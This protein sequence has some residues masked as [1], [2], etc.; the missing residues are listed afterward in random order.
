MELWCE[1]ASPVFFSSSLAALVVCGSPVCH[2]DPY[3]CYFRVISCLPVSPWDPRAVE[4]ASRS[5]SVRG[6][7]GLE[8]EPCGVRQKPGGP[9][10]R[11]AALQCG[12]P[13]S[14]LRFIKLDWGFPR[15]HQRVFCAQDLNYISNYY[16]LVF[17]SCPSKF[18]SWFY[19]ISITENNKLCIQKRYLICYIC[20][21][22][23]ASTLW[24]LETLAD[25]KVFCFWHNK[26]SSWV[27]HDIISKHCEV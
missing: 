21:R 22:V 11:Q 26:V 6:E 1:V 18:H 23:L 24:L 3:G 15:L 5:C 16:C 25:L 17:L 4:P 27:F 19:F 13:H 10:V 9:R 8:T 7:P 12:I 14:T 20:L 2:Q